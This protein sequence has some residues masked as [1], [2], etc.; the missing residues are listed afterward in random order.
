M[1][2]LKTLRGWLG[3]L[4]AC[5]N[6]MACPHGLC[7]LVAIEWDGTAVYECQSCGKH[8]FKGLR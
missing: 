1:A 5:V 6:R 4:M 3:R 7:K 2:A 8:I